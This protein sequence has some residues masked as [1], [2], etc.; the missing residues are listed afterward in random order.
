MVQAKVLHD[1]AQSE[2][3]S[4][5][6]HSLQPEAVLWAV[7]YLLHDQLR[8]AAAAPGSPLLLAAALHPNLVSPEQIINCWHDRMLRRLPIQSV[9]LPKRPPGCS[10][11]LLSLMI[12]AWNLTP[13]LA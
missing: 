5:A 2:L 8:I 11:L 12:V 9:L 4:A 10:K 6:G 13:L 7:H 3:H 1:D